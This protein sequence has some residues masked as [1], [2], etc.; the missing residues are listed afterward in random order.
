MLIVNN[1]NRTLEN[2][3]V[4][5]SELGLPPRVAVRDLWAHTDNGT[6]TVL[7]AT[8]IEPHDGSS[9]C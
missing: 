9:C 3:V 8:A 4:E 5:L 7:R 1:Y 6:C 2:M